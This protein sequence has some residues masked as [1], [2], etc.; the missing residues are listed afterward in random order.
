MSRWNRKQL[1]CPPPALHPSLESIRGPQQDRVLDRVSDADS[2]GHGAGT[3]VF[4]SAGRGPHTEG[5]GSR[6]PAGL[7]PPGTWRLDPG[8]PRWAL[9]ESSGDG[10]EDAAG[11]KGGDC[12]WVG[13]PGS[14]EDWPGWGS[15]A[16]PS[17]PPLEPVA[18]SSWFP[19]MP[20]NPMLRG[21]RC[22]SSQLSLLQTAAGIWIY[23]C[24]QAKSLQSCPTLQLYD[25]PDS[26]VHGILQAR[27]LEWVVI[28]F[29][30]GS[31]CPRNGTRV[32]CLDR[33][34]LSH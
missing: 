15:L 8:R 9:K 22:P 31:S 30:R 7:R 10:G 27:I 23:A 32:S 25:P 26:S 20:V 4:L 3:P 21:C 12:P 2:P 6:V 13:K 16:P 28:P 1:K 33:Q 17:S 11:P 18:G 24:M 19:H 29:S 14:T 34:T 5:W